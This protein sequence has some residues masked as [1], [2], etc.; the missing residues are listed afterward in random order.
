MTDEVSMPIYNKYH[1]DGLGLMQIGHGRITLAEV[2]VANHELANSP[3]KTAGRTYGLIDLTD[4][5][6]MDMTGM[7][8]QAAANVGKRVILQPGAKVAIVAPSDAA[9]GLSRIWEVFVEP[10]GW[11]TR[12]FRDR[13]KA[14]EWVV[15]QDD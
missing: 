8:M 11:K 13:A 2:L 14:F 7:D 5:T 3:D 9:F 10:A 15:S 12:V 6:E 1:E 4:V